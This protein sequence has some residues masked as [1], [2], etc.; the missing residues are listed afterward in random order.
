[1]YQRIMS[2]GTRHTQTGC[3]SPKSTAHVFRDVPQND[4]DN[5]SRRA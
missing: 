5:P 4:T 1:M 2:T 3:E